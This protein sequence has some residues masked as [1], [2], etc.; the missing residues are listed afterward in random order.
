MPPQEAA[1]PVIISWERDPETEL[2]A[3]EMET[4]TCL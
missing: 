1:G 4:I 2:E 3:V